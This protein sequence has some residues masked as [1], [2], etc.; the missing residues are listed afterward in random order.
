MFQGIYL[1][2]E[3]PEVEG[4]GLASLQPAILKHKIKREFTNQ[5]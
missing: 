4:C 5:K 3:T 2:L 1:S